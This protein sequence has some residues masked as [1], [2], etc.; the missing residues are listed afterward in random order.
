MSKLVEKTIGELLDYNFLIPSYQRGYRWEKTQVEDL[1]RDIWEFITKPQKNNNEWY[2]LQPIV[3]KEKK[4]NTFEVIDGQQRLTTIYL[5]L[6]HLE[7]VIDGD[8][9]FF[10]LEYETRKDSMDFLLK[11]DESRSEEN[12]DFFYIFDAY[13]TI[14]NWFNDLANSGEKSLSA[15]FI[16]PFLENTK[17]IW[18]EISSDKDE[19][20]I[21]TRTNM[22]KIP[23]TDSELIKALFL[24]SSNFTYASDEEFRL[25][26]LEIASEWDRIEYTLQNDEF[27]YFI[28]NIHDKPYNR[29]DYI[30]NL[31]KDMESDQKY[32]IPYSIF[33]F[34]FDKF[35]SG[36]NNE[37]DIRWKEIK[38]VF[39]TLEEWYLDYELYHKIGFLVVNQSNLKDL[40]LESNIKTK[41]QFKA[42]LDSKI[43]DPLKDEKIDEYIYGPNSKKIKS[44]LLL[45]NINTLLS[46]KNET[47]RFPFDRFK[48]ENWDIEHI[49]AIAAEV[50]VKQENQKEWLT[51]NFIK[52]TDHSDD[53]LNNKIDNLMKGDNSISDEDFQLIIEY[54][55]SEED[56]SLRN[57]CLL[58]RGTNRSYKN[59]AFN[60]K[61]SIIIGNEKKGTFIPICTRNIFM[62]YY[63]DQLIDLDLW[64]EKD[65]TS[66]I[67]NIK[68][69]L[70]N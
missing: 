25:R 37:V 51:N 60:H 12:I 67:D 47:N 69:I 55:L 50:K 63:S 16:T 56:N 70:S 57:L 29:I 14:N 38:R 7:K 53:I 22:G 36:D 39:Q 34:Y 52:T 45:H 4:D 19:I 41:S 27:W 28:T 58:D 8:R 2:C 46:S 3:V 26:Q 61:R 21:F 48:N 13:K 5:I 18:F 59:S 17:V 6:K 43:S 9:K 68:E 31:I 49:H 10:E 1:L 11:I 40:L 15:K 23:L 62:K 65:R 20:E 30:F 35:K 24:N 44:I 64:N 33:R 32:D 66:Y 42:F 54:V